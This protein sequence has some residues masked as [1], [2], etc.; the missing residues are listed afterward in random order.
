MAFLDNSGDII[1]DAVLTDTGRRRLARGD[2]SFRIA[3]FALGDDEINY[4][5]YNAAHASG[6]AYYDLEVL[7]TPILEGFT[8]PEAS[9]HHRLVTLTRNDVLYMPILQLFESGDLGSVRDSTTNSYLIAVDSATQT[10][11]GTTTGVIWGETPSSV[12]STKIAVDQGTDKNGSPP[13]TVPLD[14]DL[15]ETRYQ[16]EIDNRLGGLF[17]TSGARARVSFVNEAQM[18]SYYVTTSNRRFVSEISSTDASDSSINGPRGTRVQF[19]IG[20][21]LELNGS[22]T[23]F[24]RFGGTSTV[25]STSCRHIDSIARVTGV[26]TGHSIDIPIRFIKKI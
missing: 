9:M 23:L 13:A 11:V 21:S 4:R 7:Q 26:T 10:A 22:N 16:I 8:D 18:A 3:K 2:G 20:A 19:K 12:S 25:G 17:S 24:N 14:A 5:L 6:S 1:L 15:I